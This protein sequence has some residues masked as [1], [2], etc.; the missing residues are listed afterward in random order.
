MEKDRGEAMVLEVSPEFNTP[1]VVR[2]PRR[3]RERLLSDCSNKKTVSSVQDIEDKLLH[4]HLRR[5]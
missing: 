5:Q 1:A 3:I 4:A 2:V